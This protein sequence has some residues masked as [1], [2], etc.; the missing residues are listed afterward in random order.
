MPQVVD[1]GYFKSIF[2][3][4]LPLHKTDDYIKT[5]PRQQLLSSRHL[6]RNKTRRRSSCRALPEV[7]Q[8]TPL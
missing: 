7:G 6:R 3:W 4:I 2:Q 1:Q 5:N 8:A